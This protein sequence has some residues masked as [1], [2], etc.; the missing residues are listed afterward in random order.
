MRASTSHLRRLAAIAAA[1]GSL[2]LVACGGDDGSSSSEPEEGSVSPEQ[3]VSEIGEV[4][5]G[6]DASLTAYEDGDAEQA[7]ELA[8]DAYLE[9]FELVEGPLEEVDPALNEGLEELIR[10]QLRGA[11]TD[12]RS[13]AQVSDLVERAQDDLDQAESRLEGAPG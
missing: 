3:A 12:G 7:E 1:T 8:A 2:A 11:I 4:R 9:H 5:D 13:P 6:L 10:E